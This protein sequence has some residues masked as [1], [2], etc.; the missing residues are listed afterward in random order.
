MP[1][2]TI[3]EAPLEVQN[4]QPE[5]ELGPTQT[6]M[7]TAIHFLRGRHKYLRES[8]PNHLAKHECGVL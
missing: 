5:V 4:A 1:Q 3:G 8:F 7:Q 2:G 6:G